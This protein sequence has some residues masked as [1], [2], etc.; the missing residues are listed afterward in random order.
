MEWKDLK[1]EDIIVM[2]YYAEKYDE[3]VQRKGIV[4]Y[5]Y[6]NL[7]IHIVTTNS[8]WSYWL[9]DNIGFSIHDKKMK[10]KLLKVWRL[11]GKDYKNIHDKSGIL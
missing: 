8:Q 4:D 6:D 2:E 9:K 7:S 5:V 1:E 10:P 3:V 11:E